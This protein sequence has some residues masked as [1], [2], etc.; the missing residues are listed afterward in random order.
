MRVFIA[1]EDIYHAGNP[2]IFTLV[3]SV[4]SRHNDIEFGWGWKEFWSDEIY[5]YDV[6]HF[7]WPQAYMAPCPKEQAASM[8][9]RRIIELRHHGV[10]IVATCHDLK[11]HYS[12]LADYAAC[13]SVVYSMADAIFHLGLYS[14]NLFEQEYPK[15][16]HFY[17]PHHLYDELYTK[18]PTREESIQKLNLN[19]KKHYVLCFGSFRA[20]I[21]RQLVISLAQYLGNDYAI[22]APSFMQVR[23]HHRPVLRLIPTKSMIW[24]FMYEKKY[25]II[26]S[27]KSWAPVDDDT[28][29]YYYGASEFAFVQRVNILN[30]GNAVMPLLFNKVVVGPSVANVGQFLMHYG[31]PT[32]DPQNQ[33]SLFKAVEKGIEMTHSDQITGIFNEAFRSLSTSIVSEMLY[34]NYKIILER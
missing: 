14:K 13:I 7:Q 27:G 34:E 9:E 1:H 31:M 25:R 11:P 3:E 12:Q 2:Y 18:R 5:M 20:D 23:K 29:P 24:Q 26:M 4:L 10:K 19:P 15:T 8:L 16:K 33:N 17:M 6:V 32:F 21:E 22:L 30:S 28:L